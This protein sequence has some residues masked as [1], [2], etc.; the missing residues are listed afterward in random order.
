MNAGYNVALISLIDEI[1]MTNQLTT[2]NELYRK[3]WRA[4]YHQIMIYESVPVLVVALEY[5][6]EQRVIQ[7]PQAVNDAVSLAKAPPYDPNEGLAVAFPDEIEL[8][9]VKR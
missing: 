1:H 6:P 8:N 7:Q 5:A 4:V 3:G 2:I 9:E